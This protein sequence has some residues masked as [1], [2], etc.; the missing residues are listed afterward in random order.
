MAVYELDGIQSNLARGWTILDAPSADVIG[1]A[2]L[3]RHARVWFGA[4]LRG[5]CDI[6][7]VGE[8]ANTHR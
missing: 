2:M 3:E 4:V 5:D 6:I 1:R 8:N 7:H